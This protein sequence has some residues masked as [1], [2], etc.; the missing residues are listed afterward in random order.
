MNN[1]VSVVGLGENAKTYS[2]LG[3]LD[4]TLVQLKSLFKKEAYVS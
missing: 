1:Q 2:Y 4:L 3:L